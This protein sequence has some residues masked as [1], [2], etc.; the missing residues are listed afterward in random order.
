MADELR[1]K[2]QSVGERDEKVEPPQGEYD[3]SSLEDAG[4]RIALFPF[5]P[6]HTRFNI[7]V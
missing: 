5:P 6:P 1:E 3:D 7:L 2:N 4:V